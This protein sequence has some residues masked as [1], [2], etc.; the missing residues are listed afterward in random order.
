MAGKV[1]LVPVYTVK[2]HVGC[3]GM[4]P[5]IYELSNR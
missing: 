4:A 2:E 1:Q 3:R 5:H